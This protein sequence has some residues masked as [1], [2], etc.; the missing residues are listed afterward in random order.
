M[1]SL[2]L[3]LSLNDQYA[4]ASLYGQLF[5]QTPA[6]KIFSERLRIVANEYTCVLNS[7]HCF[8]NF[9]FDR[10]L[11]LRGHVTSFL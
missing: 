9:A 4:F 8:L 11:A 5:N 10:P 2:W 6:K 1:V 3:S 7:S